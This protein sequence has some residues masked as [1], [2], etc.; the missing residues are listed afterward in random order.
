MS[1]KRVEVTR[2]ILDSDTD[3][4]SCD[5]CFICKAYHKEFGRDTYISCSFVFIKIE[6]ETYDC[7]AELTDWQARSARDFGADYDERDEIEGDMVEPITVI[8]DDETMTAYI[9]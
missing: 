4:Y 9:E 5:M 3:A 2:E 1:K 7:S 8:F 6:S